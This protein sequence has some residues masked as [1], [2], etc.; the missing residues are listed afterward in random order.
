MLTNYEKADYFFISPEMI[1]LV[2]LLF[3]RG[4]GLEGTVRNQSPSGHF[5]EYKVFLF[6]LI[7]EFF[8]SV[9]LLSSGMTLLT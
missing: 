5:G 7:S 3:F 8:S 1:Q 2:L 4:R 6:C 9:L